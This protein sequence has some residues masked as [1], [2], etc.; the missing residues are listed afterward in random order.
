MQ[1]D[2]WPREVP[3]RGKLPF[4]QVLRTDVRLRLIALTGGKRPLK[5]PL[6]AGSTEELQQFALAVVDLVDER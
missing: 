2:A 4:D 1:L 3:K 5:T 6:D